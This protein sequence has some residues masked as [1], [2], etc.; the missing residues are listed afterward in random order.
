MYDLKAKSCSLRPR[1]GQFSRTW[2]VR[3]QGQ[4]LTLKAKD[5]KTVL[6]AATSD[7]GRL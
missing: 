5:F 4:D 1:T 3:G 7:F 2:S 6:E